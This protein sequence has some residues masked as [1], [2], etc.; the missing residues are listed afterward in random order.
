MRR[1]FSSNSAAIS[2]GVIALVLAGAVMPISGSLAQETKV[3]EDTITIGERLTRDGRMAIYGIYFGTD[4]SVVMAESDPVISAIGQLMTENPDLELA[5][6]G[7]TDAVGPHE[8]NLE[9]SKMRANSVVNALANKHGIERGR[10]YPAGAGFLIPIAPNNTERGR[11]LNRRVELVRMATIKG[12]SKPDPIADNARKMVQAMSDYMAAQ[13]TLT[14][15]YN[16]TLE[17][18]TNEGQ[19]LGLA[20]SGSVMMER[21]DKLRITRHGGFADVEV[22]YDGQKLSLL[23]KTQN[24][25]AQKNVTGSI[26]ELV[27]AMRDE[28]RPVP[29]ADLLSSDVYEALMPHVIDIRDVGSGVI[30]GH[31]CDHLA[32]RTDDVD[33]QLWISQ[34]SAPLPCRYVITTLNVAG[35]PQYSMDFINWTT[36]TAFD[37]ADFAFL[38]PENAKA[39]EPEDLEDFDELPA[40]LRPKN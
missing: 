33:W 14:F 30:N 35:N 37:P 29:A 16:S 38:P 7:H 13:E 40:H 20:S 23:G 9:L 22:T 12:E 2:R 11:A 6:V 5:I 27:D 32:F 17:V 1:K 8:H 10:L 39:L 36:G 31:E 24:I 18:V 4:K 19:K 15:D 25:F 26:D 3:M 34:G 28:G 21:P